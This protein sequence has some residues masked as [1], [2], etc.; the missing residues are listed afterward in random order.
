MRTIYALALVCFAGHLAAVPIVFTPTSQYQTSGVALAGARSDAQF[1]S[2]P[3]SLLPLITTATA[4]NATDF[5][6]GSGIAASGLLTTQAEANSAS[7][8]ASAVGSVEFI[9][10]FIGG[11][12]GLINL[13]FNFNTQDF[14]D[15]N[16]SSAGTLFVM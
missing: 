7:G 9:G 15:P 12:G 14:S 10:D 4:F 6:S 11:L 3:P 2:S 1:G 16:T 13:G 8:L 5:A